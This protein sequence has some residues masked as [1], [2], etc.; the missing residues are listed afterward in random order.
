MKK[1]TLKRRPTTPAPQR[2]VSNRD[3]LQVQ[4]SI[5]A[6][7]PKGI[8]VAPSFFQDCIQYRIQ[9]GHDH[10]AVTTRIVRWRHYDQAWREGGQGHAW[11]TLGRWLEFTTVGVTTFRRR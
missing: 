2:A 10:P 5:R 9:N 4:I 7:L 11:A 1:S 6:K 3:P 8:D